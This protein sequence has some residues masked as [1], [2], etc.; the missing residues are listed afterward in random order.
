[1]QI[2]IDVSDVQRQLGSLHKQLPFAASQA[3][4]ATS[5]DVQ[6]AIINRIH[7]V[8]NVRRPLFVQRSVKIR[9]AK[10]HDLEA[11][12]AIADL[13]GKPTADIL[14]KFETGDDK[15]PTRS[16]VLAVP[17]G[18]IRRTA[19][20]IITKQQQ[21]GNLKR[22]FYLKTKAGHEYIFQ[23]TGKPRK[24]IRMRYILKPRVQI[25]DRLRFVQTGKR[26]VD[27]VMAGHMNT[28]IKRAIATAR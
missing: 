20:G 13:G 17:A 1:M 27:R 2:S 18:D 21:L 12:I 5:K 10:K 25:D 9:F 8:F 4:N 16:R 22:S 15:L 3:I 26:V 28:A 7:N 23:R 14:S 6:K 11:Q 19:R 24:A